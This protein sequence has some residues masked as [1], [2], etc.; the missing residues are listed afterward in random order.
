MHQ[1][2]FN[3]LPQD[4]WACGDF[5]YFSVFIEN[6]QMPAVSMAFKQK[7]VAR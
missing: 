5:H 4:I 2:L 7:A 6:I 1:Q 3:E